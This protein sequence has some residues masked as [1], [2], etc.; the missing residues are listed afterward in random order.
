[1]QL[2]QITTGADQQPLASHCLQPSM[3]KTAKAHRR[4]NLAKH[5]FHGLA[6][7]AINGFSSLRSQLA[8]HSLP[9]TGIFG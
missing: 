3:K 9:L 7:L 1:M 5:W 8:C 2:H 4:F 6:T